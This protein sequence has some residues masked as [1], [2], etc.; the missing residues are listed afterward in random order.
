MWPVTAVAAAT[1]TRKI[2]FALRMPHASHE[3]PVARRKTTFSRGEN[4]YVSAQTGAAGRGAHG[5]AASMKM[6]R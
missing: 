5:G 3:V 6:S 1:G 2:D 4:A